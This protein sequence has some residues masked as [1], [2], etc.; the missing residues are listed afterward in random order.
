MNFSS[1][2]GGKNYYG[3]VKSNND[4]YSLEDGGDPG[5]NHLIIIEKNEGVSRNFASDLEY[6]DH[7]LSN[8]EQ[9][10]R[11]YYL[12]FATTTEELLSA[13]EARNIFEFVISGV[14]CGYE[15]PDNC[16]TARLISQRVGVDC[17]D[18]GLDEVIVY[19]VDGVGN[20]D[21]CTFE[22]EVQDTVGPVIFCPSD[23]TIIIDSGLCGIVIDYGILSG[24][25]TEHWA[26][27]VIDFSSEYSTTTWSAEKILGMP[28]VYPMY[29]DFEDAW[30]QETEDDQREF[31]EIEYLPPVNPYRIDIYETYNPGAVDTIYLRNYESGEWIIVWSDSA[32]VPN[33]PEQS[34]IFSVDFPQTSYLV[35]AVRLA[36]NSPAIEGWNEY[37]AVALIDSV[38]QYESVEVNEICITS[39]GVLQTSGLP[40]GSFYPVG[41]TFNKFEVEDAGGNS[42][43][44]SFTI[45]VMNQ[46]SMCCSD[47]LL[48][49]EIVIPTGIYRTNGI[50]IANGN[51][52]QGSKVKFQAANGIFLDPSFF[53]RRKGFV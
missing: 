30:A 29:G 23:T 17:S 22:L 35:D 45:E 8:L 34:R 26:R 44:C 4:G 32:A 52:F 13:E 3:Y 18:V 41:T 21:S 25:Q 9:N 37:D 28:D 42:A 47:T 27:R 15:V 6:D 1:S 19:A 16:G 12:L 51:I 38:A 39:D 14:L 24:Y 11:I 5:V 7:S 48:I 40:T 10:S 20:V 33:P 53:C 49:D 36:I 43:T 2:C 50:I 46:D 31:I